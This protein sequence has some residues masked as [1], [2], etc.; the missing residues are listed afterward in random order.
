M[1][2][3]CHSINYRTYRYLM[4]SRVQ[5]M[6]RTKK[7][8]GTG[9]LDLLK[10]QETFLDKKQNTTTTFLTTGTSTAALCVRN[11]NWYIILEV[12]FL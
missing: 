5:N 4:R 7:R 11:L 10:Y 9:Y 1:G 6:K 3:Y 12:V 2:N 8:K